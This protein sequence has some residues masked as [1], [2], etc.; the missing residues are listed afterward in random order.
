MLFV[1]VT[2]CLV[3]RPDDSALLLCRKYSVKCGSKIVPAVGY[4]EQHQ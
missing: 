4:Q 3:S 1:L 2:E